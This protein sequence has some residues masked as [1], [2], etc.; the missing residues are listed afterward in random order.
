MTSVANVD[1]RRA[2]PVLGTFERY[3]T[4]WV[5]L[6][7]VAGIV[8]GRLLPG[9]FQALGRMNVAEVN[10]PVAV[11]IWLMIV[12]ML[13]K[14]D[15]GALHQLAAQ[16]RGH[17]GVRFGGTAWDEEARVALGALKLANGIE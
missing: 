16:W 12:P 4:V 10:I 9:P 5:A 15:F 11:L 3:L 7:I 6:C 8:L 13:L 14:V 17:F 2:A 1:R